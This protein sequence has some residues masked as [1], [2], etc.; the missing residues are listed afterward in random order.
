MGLFRTVAE[1]D[2]RRREVVELQPGFFNV[3]SSAL[4]GSGTQSLRSE[5]ARFDHTVLS[6][7]RTTGHALDID[8]EDHLV[9]GT[10]VN[11]RALLSVKEHKLEIPASGRSFS[12]PARRQSWH[13]G[14]SDPE[15]LHLSLIVPKRIVSETLAAQGARLKG[16]DRVLLFDDR[17]D[18]DRELLDFMLF[19]AGACDSPTSALS[20]PPSRGAIES[21]LVDQYCALL[22][23][24]DLVVSRQEASGGGYGR[25]VARAEDFMQ[26]NLDRPLSISAVAQALDTT[27]RQLQYAFRQVREQTPRQA[28]Q[29]LRLDRARK[30]LTN[31]ADDTTVTEVAMDLG[32][33]HLSRFAAAYRQRYNETPSH[34]LRAAR[35]TDRM[36]EGGLVLA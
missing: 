21:L 17:N 30:M 5:A 31:P 22:E 25:L 10:V 6:R 20:R 26:E 23:R 4:I 12:T 33:L 2:E 28:L 29:A 14:D 36:D 34:T 16:D 8:F 24:M 18:G 19:L 32:I 1:A 11:G 7:M 9:Y 3:R 27:P 35:G 13:L 15:Y